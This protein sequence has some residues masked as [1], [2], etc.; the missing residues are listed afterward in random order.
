MLLAEPIKHSLASLSEAVHHLSSLFF[1][2]QWRQ[3]DRS[4]ANRLN[5]FLR[6]DR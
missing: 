5:I 4:E 6:F 1:T 3:L 2:L